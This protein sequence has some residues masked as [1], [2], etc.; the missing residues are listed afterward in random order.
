MWYSFFSSSVIY[1]IE[2]V[3][4]MAMSL[5]LHSLNENAHE[6]P[7]MSNAMAISNSCRKYHC[8]TAS[9]WFCPRFKRLLATWSASVN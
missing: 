8:S 5:A 9:L 4:F 1:M 2:H 7:I 6:M 3:I